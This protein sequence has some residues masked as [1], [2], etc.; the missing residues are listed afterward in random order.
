MTKA[1]NERRVWLYI[2]DGASTVDLR[3]LDH[4]D[5]LTWGANSHT[6]KGDIILMYRGAPYKDIF[7]SFEALS[8]PE[9]ADRRSQVYLPDIILLGKKRRV[10]RPITLDD[11]RADPIL[12]KWSGSRSPQGVMQR[13]QDL[14]AEG[15][16]PRL[17]KLLQY[18]DVSEVRHSPAD[19]KIFLSYGRADEEK[20]R[21]LATRLAAA[22]FR[23]AWLDRSKLK[24]GEMWRGEIKQALSESDVVIVC[25]SSKAVSKPK[26][27]FLH[28]E[29][30][31][32]V[33]QALALG[34]N[35]L[36]I[37]ARLDEC[38]I[39][40]RPRRWHSADLYRR[41][42]FASLVKRLRIKSSE[43]HVCQSTA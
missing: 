30:G 4:L 24:P 40:H 29:I 10:P 14:I 6:R 43:R 37:P 26:S 2:A 36:I 38:I 15:V 34:S 31:W 19:L 25:L 17:K 18:Q 39:P 32:A 35:T 12:R 8:D 41:G 16:W 23:G 42:G 9:P 13:R 21:R 11:L 3:D 27:D 33:Q 7:Y 5:S 28:T 22:G 1:A 20:V